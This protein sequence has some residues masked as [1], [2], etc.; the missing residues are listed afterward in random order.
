MHHFNV[1]T[2]ICSKDCRVERKCLLTAT[3][4]T[5]T[6]YCGLFIVIMEFC[7]IVPMTVVIISLTIIQTASTTISTANKTNKNL[8]QLNEHRYSTFCLLKCG[9][10]FKELFKLNVEFSYHTQNRQKSND[11]QQQSTEKVFGDK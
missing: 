6:F 9:N 1:C 8:A 4:T 7:A 3:Y 10:N 11:F 5:H 2:K